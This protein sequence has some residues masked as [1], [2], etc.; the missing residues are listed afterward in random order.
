MVVERQEVEVSRVFVPASEQ[1]LRFFEFLRLW[2]RADFLWEA[3]ERR[4]SGGQRSEVSER[5]PT[6]LGWLLM[7]TGLHSEGEAVLWAF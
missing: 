2:M 3:E 6:G 1:A 4:Q 5:R 7:T